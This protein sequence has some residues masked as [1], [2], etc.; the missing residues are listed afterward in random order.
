MT[1]TALTDSTISTDSPRVCVCGRAFLQ[2]HAF[3]NHQR[4]CPKSKKRLSGALAKAKELWGAKKRRRTDSSIDVQNTQT[5]TAIPRVP[6]LTA[7]SLGDVGALISTT[8]AGDT[9]YNVQIA[10]AT[11]IIPTDYTQEAD[12]PDLITNDSEVRAISRVHILSRLIG[13]T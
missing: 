9:H 4:S 1:L 12:H 13:M 8:N 6:E 7:S 11:D 10:L 2:L 5:P 3:G